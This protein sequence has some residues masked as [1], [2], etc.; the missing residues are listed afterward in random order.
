MALNTKKSTCLKTLAISTKTKDRGFTVI[1]LLVSIAVITLLAV[2]SFNA[3]T[4][5]T[6]RQELNAAVTDIISVLEEARLLTLAAK[7]NIAYG[8]HFN[9]EDVTLFSGSSYV[10]SA[11][12]NVV[13]KLTSRVHIATTSFAGG[14]QDVFFDRLTGKTN[15]SGTLIVSFKSDTS[16]STTVTIHATGVVE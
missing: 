14:G 2:L 8:V 6:K 4:R 7:K 5:F 10:V 11:S 1:E 9:T 3:F 13:T 16:A 15:N 12:D